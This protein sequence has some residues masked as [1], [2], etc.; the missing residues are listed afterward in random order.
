MTVYNSTEEERS[1]DEVSM[2]FHWSAIEFLSVKGSSYS[3]A[4]LVLGSCQEP[5][6][7]KEVDRIMHSVGVCLQ[8]AAAM[9]RAHSVIGHS[10]GSFTQR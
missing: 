2:F 4:E 1:L 10:L 5:S 3:T 6:G 9:G 8:D 7:C